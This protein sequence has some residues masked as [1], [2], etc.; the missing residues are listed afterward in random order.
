VD[1]LILSLSLSFVSD[2]EPASLKLHYALEEVP[3]SNCV[4]RI[5]VV[6]DH[7]T[8]MRVQKDVFG[9]VRPDLLATKICHIKDLKLKVVKDLANK[10]LEV[11]KFW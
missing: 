6:V 11:G 4:Y 7:A 1:F 5:M 9:D 2:D 8:C 10:M 3:V